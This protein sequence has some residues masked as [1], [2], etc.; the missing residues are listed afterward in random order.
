[1][2]RRLFFAA[3]F[4]LAVLFALGTATAT[5]ATQA[6][7]RL[8]YEPPAS[9]APLDIN[10]D[11][12]ADNPA[13]DAQDLLNPALPG[14]GFCLLGFYCELDPTKVGAVSFGYKIA[15][16]V[17][18]FLGLVFVVIL[19][20][21]GF[22]MLTSFGDEDGYK[23]GKSAAIAAVVGFLLLSVAYI[24]VRALIVITK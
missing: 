13:F 8:P 1:M 12:G 19:I 23:T 6:P 21:G 2:T 18:S 7:V 14:P 22:R 15:N 9:A 11:P 10:V 20:Y 17:F 24:V 5:A 3:F 4:G 16:F